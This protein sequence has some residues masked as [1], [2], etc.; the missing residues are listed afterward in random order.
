MA[1]YVKY[2]DFSEQLCAGVHNLTASGHVVK[3]AIHTDAPV[4]ASDTGLS[5]L[6][7]ITGTGYTS[8][9]ED[10]QNT[11]SESS[12]TATVAA[13]DVTWTASAADWSSSA[14][15]VSIY[16]DTATSPADALIASWDY[17]ATFLVGNGESFSLDFGASVFTLA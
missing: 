5:N 16:N 1:S 4:V 7:Q 11:L 15:Y 12:G 2:Q 8:G 13:T 9:G 6:T 10:I 17:G 14:R 3:A